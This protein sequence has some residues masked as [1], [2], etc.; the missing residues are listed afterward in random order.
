MPRE[1]KL[2]FEFEEK[3]FTLLLKREVWGYFWLE[4]AT[5]S[6]KLKF[7]PQVQISIFL[8]K[9]TQNDHIRLLYTF[10]NNQKKI[11]CFGSCGYAQASVKKYLSLGPVD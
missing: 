3:K 11:G 5:F 6:N 7:L 9:A 1:E 2:K 8:H 4:N 10:E